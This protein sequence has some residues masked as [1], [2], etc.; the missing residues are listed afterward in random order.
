M[1]RRGGGSLPKRNEK[2][3]E[4]VLSRIGIP[5][6]RVHGV[7]RDPPSSPLLADRERKRFLAF[8]RNDDAGRRHTPS[9]PW[10]EVPRRGG[11]SLPKRDEKECETVLSRIG[12]PR[13]RVH[14]VSRDPSSPPLLPDRERKGFLAFAR[15]DDAGGGILPPSPG[16]R[17]PERAEVGSRYRMKRNGRQ[18]FHVLSSLARQGIF[19]VCRFLFPVQACI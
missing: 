10:K 15:N 14:G 2:E 9:F 3:C 19:L 5:R 11:G 17:C 4:T 16:R 1:P 18:S 13:R 8:A 6:R 12:I 7:S